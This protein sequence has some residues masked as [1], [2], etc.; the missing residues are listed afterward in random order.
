MLLK[1][2]SEVRIVDHVLT[3][4]SSAATKESDHEEEIVELQRLL[5]INVLRKLDLRLGG[6]VFEAT[7]QRIEQIDGVIDGLLRGDFQAQCSQPPLV[8]PLLQQAVRSRLTSMLAAAAADEL[9]RAPYAAHLTIP[10]L[11]QG[12]MPALRE[13][14]A[15]KGSN[16]HD[17][18]ADIESRVDDLMAA[19]GRSFASQLLENHKRYLVSSDLKRTLF[20]TIFGYGPLQELIDS[21]DV[22]EIMV[23]HPSLIYV[24]RA[25]RVVR[26]RKRFTSPEAATAVLERI[27]APMGRRIDRSQPLVDARLSDGSRVNAIIEPLA[28]HGACITIRKFPARSVTVEDLLRWGSINPLA[29]EFLAAAVRYRANLVIAGGTGSGKTTLLNVLSGMIPRHERL[30]T[31]E[32]AAEL[33]LQQEH[34]VALETRPASA[35]GSGEVAIRDLVK[36]ALRMRPDRIIVGE[37]RGGEALDMLQAMNTGHAGSMTTLHANSAEDV[38]SRL[39]TMVLTAADL[40]LSAV[41]QQLARSLDLVVYIRR[42]PRGRRMVTQ[43]SEVTGINPVSGEVELRDLMRADGPEAGAALALTGYL[44]TFLNEMVEQGHLDLQRWLRGSDAQ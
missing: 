43:V 27:V 9:P 17:G 18:A 36:N 30:V 39:E 35:E 42:L 33:R 23:V 41:R 11:E 1:P 14:L 16:G 13:M 37:C 34:V 20:D 12:I 5:H 3:I 38:I 28:I 40:P 8:G 31:I 4:E 10:A 2:V 6:G 15:Q 22:S 26:T 32:D 44:P 29:A 21:P 24:E 19:R 25:G 7:Q